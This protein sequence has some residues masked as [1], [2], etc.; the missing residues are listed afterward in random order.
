MPKHAVVVGL[1]ALVVA[2]AGSS[3]LI[4]GAL[5]QPRTPAATAHR[6][7]VGPKPTPRWYWHWQAWRLGEG[8][9][10]GR[11][12]R[13]N[14]R[15]ERAPHPV[16]RWAWRRLHFVLLARQLSG[17]GVGFAQAVAYTQSRP[18][19]VPLREI[20]VSSAAGFRS[21][22][23][24]LRA[25]DLVRATGP[26][27]V[28]GT[29]VITSQLSSWAVL[30]LGSY[31]TFDYTG[32]QNYAAV[33]LHNPSYLRIY[34]G[35]LTTEDT[36]GACLLSHGM[37]QVLWWGFYV[38]DCGGTGVGLMGANDGGPT[39][40]NDFEGEVTK[41]GQNL[42]WDPHTEKGSGEHCVN[43][44][45]GGYFPYH[46]N[47]FAFYC[48]DIPTGAAIEYGSS[49]DYAP[50]NNSIILK[51]V[52]L[53][54][55][56]Q[57]QTGGNAIQFWGIG[58]QSADI[59]YLEVEQAQGY[60]LFDGGMYSGTSLSGVTLEYGRATNTNQNPRYTGKGPW[61]SAHGVAYRNIQ[62]ARRA[63]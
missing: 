38:H 2:G 59:K 32:G 62:P 34:G 45:D 44:D 15:P 33:Y 46:D 4:G 31:V 42:A 51:A 57:I 20:D 26:F 21:A 18:A 11:R 53:T 35:T 7:G 55:V 8:Y 1:V 61:D 60:G 48:H 52:N 40:G 9:A 14:L 12:L 23:S 58:G 56:S 10:K 3:P 36:G 17:G 43:L 63:G 13:R 41:V 39:S 22:L 24:G 30:D 5:A 29:T 47:R 37:Q 49:R 16:P 54:F 25:G 6:Q 50:Q 28:S 27:T 19:F